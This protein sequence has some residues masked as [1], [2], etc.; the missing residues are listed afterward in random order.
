MKA[1]LLRA[2]RR[3]PSVYVVDE[4]EWRYS[5][6]AHGPGGTQVAVVRAVLAR[7]DYE[8]DLFGR[9][10]KARKGVPVIRYVIPPRINYWDFT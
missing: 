10:F 2:A 7:D 9:G 3:M 8:R 6:D 4:P 1:W 5:A